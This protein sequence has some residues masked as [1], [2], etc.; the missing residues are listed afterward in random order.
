ME[1]IKPRY[2]IP[3]R[4]RSYIDFVELTI[5][6]MVDD[7]TKNYPINS[8]EFWNNKKDGIDVDSIIHIINELIKV[9]DTLDALT[10]MVSILPEQGLA[11]QHRDSLITTL[12][13]KLDIIV[14]MY[15]GDD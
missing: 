8:I 10:P 11:M 2:G 12:Y 5:H 6:K 3:Q 7:D 15:L 4:P 14:S 1:K 13:D 9:A